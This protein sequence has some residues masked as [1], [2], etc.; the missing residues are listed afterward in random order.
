MSA[1]IKMAMLKY[2]IGAIER[3]E[4][5][6]IWPLVSND[7]ERAC[8]EILQPDDVLRWLVTNTATL[9]VVVDTETSEYIAHAVTRCHEAHGHRWLEVATLGGTLFGHW[10]DQ[11]QARLIETARKNRCTSITCQTHRPGLVKWLEALK[12]SVRSYTLEYQIDGR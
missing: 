2:E 4:I 6:D 5:S 11:L 3:D 12:Y 10:C 8:D 9:W 7:V 1:V